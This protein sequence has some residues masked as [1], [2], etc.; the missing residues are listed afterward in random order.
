[1]R[2]ISWMD[3]PS[4]HAWLGHRQ[5]EL[6]AFYDAAVDGVNGGF[7]WLDAH[8]RPLEAEGK[9][10]WLNARMTY[11]AAIGAL[12]GRP[13][14]AAR[15]DHGLDALISGPLRDAAHGGWFN[16]LDA[17]N[18]PVDDTKQAYGH[19]F[20]LL[21]A[22]AAL[23]AGH[24][25]ARPLF[26]DALQLLDD[27]FWHE[28]A[29]MYADSWNRD[30]SALS[31]YRG[32]N[33]NMHLVEALL[34]A[35]EITG[36]PELAARA[37]RIAERL[38]HRVSSQHDWRLPEHFSPDWVPDLE[39]N[40]SDPTNRFTP[41]G[42]T[43]GHLLEWARLLLQLNAALPAPAAWIPSAAVQLFDRA[44]ADGWGNGAPGFSYTNGWRG[45][46][47]NADRYHWV[48]A[49]A[50]GAAVALFRATGNS[51]YS[52]W[53]ARFWDH[54][55]TH[56]IDADGSWWHELDPEN[57]RIAEIWEGKPDLYHALQATL[58]ARLSTLQSV[59][60]SLASGSLASGPLASG[61]R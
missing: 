53:Y 49:E 8:G 6:F 15:V 25:R 21:A 39:F 55:A 29:G 33:A 40:A 47:V 43:N 7:W 28:S 52:D 56:H 59:A 38:I 26:H 36:D 37:L 41:Y 61:A 31:D 23:T 10:L 20:V 4:H 9:Q 54:A 12:L 16:A 13:G 22:A 11:T 24:E 30:F 27:R 35:H 44:V 42:S 45:E 57:A 14:S 1:M 5:D 17:Q 58:F 3:N 50:I 2:P 46:V 18:V 34:L 32:Q 51:V 60:G 19:A 48:I